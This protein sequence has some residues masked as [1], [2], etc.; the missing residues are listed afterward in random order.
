MATRLSGLALGGKTYK[1]KFGHHGGNQPVMNL[2]TRKVEITAQNHG[3]AVDPDSL[4]ANE[5]ALTHINLNDQTL[6]GLRHKIAAAFQRA[7]SP[8]S[9][10]RPA[11][12]GVPFQSVRG[13]D[14]GV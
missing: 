3:F 10:A 9:F 1:L 5:V 11:R 2:E 8:R 6:E 13:D 7:V 14:G 4:N 12:L